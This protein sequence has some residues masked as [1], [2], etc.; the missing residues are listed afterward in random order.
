[1]DRTALAG[2]LMD[3]F[4]ERNRRYLWTDAFAVCNLL[5]L[6]RTGEAHALI[7]RVHAVLGRHRPDDPRQGPIPGLRIGKPLP[8]RA[9]GELVDDELEWDRDGQYFHYLTRWMHALHQAGEGARAIELARIAHRA[10]VH[11]SPPRMYWKMSVDL[12]RPLVTSMG[13][14]DPLDGLITCLELDPDALAEPIRDYLA[15]IHPEAMVTVDP[16]GLGGLLVDASRA[17]QLGHRALHDQLVTIAEVGL[18]HVAPRFDPRER[19]DR[20]L[21][22]R[23]LGLAIGLAAVATAHARLGAAIVDFWLEPASRRAPSWI[24]HQDINDVMLATAL[25]PDGYLVLGSPGARS[26]STAARSGGIL[27]P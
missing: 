21:A 19:A 8:E 23:E 3:R 7:E 2:E 12:T 11:G 9:P 25:A 1:M 15:M 10:F 5:G 6:G 13:Q 14:H 17:A 20:R 26:A 27:A 4:L 16:L 18:D 24:D 22:F